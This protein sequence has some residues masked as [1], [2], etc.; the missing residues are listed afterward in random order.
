LKRILKKHNVRMPPELTWLRTDRQ[1][2]LIITMNENSTVLAYDTVSTGSHQR[3]WC[4][5][6][7]KL[8]EYLEDY[9]FP[10]VLCCTELCDV[11]ILCCWRYITSVRNPVQNRFHWRRTHFDS[12]KHR[13]RWTFA[14]RHDVR[15]RNTRNLHGVSFSVQHTHCLLVVSRKSRHDSVYNYINGL[16]KIT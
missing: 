2:L 10:Q 3:F 7:S 14:Y 6:W 11:R 8:L 9:E 15:S 12:S 1:S 13:R 5:S 16:R 4:A